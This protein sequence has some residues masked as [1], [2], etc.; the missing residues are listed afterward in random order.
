MIADML[1]GFTP[2]ERE[3]F[4]NYLER[5]RANLLRQTEQDVVNG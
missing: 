5:V 4:A 1:E 3:A 2:I